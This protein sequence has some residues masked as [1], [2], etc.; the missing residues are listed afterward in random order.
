MADWFVAHPIAAGAIGLPI[1]ALYFL[2]LYK[3]EKKI[4]KEKNETISNNE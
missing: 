2:V 3:L 4:K 1:A